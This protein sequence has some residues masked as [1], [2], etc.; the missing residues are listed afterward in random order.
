MCFAAFTALQV[1]GYVPIR[2]YTVDFENCIFFVFP[3]RFFMTHVY[4][5]YWR[6]HKVHS[7]ALIYVY[8]QV[9]TYNRVLDVKEKL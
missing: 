2:I 8:I 3:L 4:H 6:T 5:V 1:R 7:V 9:R